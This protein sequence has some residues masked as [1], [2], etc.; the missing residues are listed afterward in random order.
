MRVGVQ[1]PGPLRAEKCRT[2]QQQAGAVALLPGAVGDDLATAGCR[3]A[4]RRRCTFGALA[5]TRGTTI[6]GVAGVGR[7]ERPLRV[8]LQPVVQLLDDPG[9]ELGDQRLD[10]HAGE[11]RGEQP[12]EP[13]PSWLRSAISAVAAPGYWILTAT[14]RPS[15]QV[16][17]VHLADAGRR[18]RLVVERW[19]ALAPRPA[20][21]LGEHRVH[22]AHRHRRRRLLQLGQRLAVG[23][24]DLLGQRGLEDRQRLAE[25]HRPALE[26]AQD[27]EEL[28]GGALLQ[29]GGDRSAGRPA[30]PLAEPEGGAPGRPA[31]AAA[32]AELAPC[33]VTGPSSVSV[34]LAAHDAPSRGRS[35]A[36]AS[37]SAAAC[38]LVQRAAPGAAVHAR[39]RQTAGRARPSSSVASSGARRRRPGRRWVEDLPGRP[40]PAGAA[41]GQQAGR[42]STARRGLGRGAAGRRAGARRGSAS[43]RCRSAAAQAAGAPGTTSGPTTPGLAAHVATRCGTPARVEPAASGSRGRPRRARARPG[44]RR[45]AGGQRAAGR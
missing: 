33:G 42:P 32:A 27:G 11:E 2:R 6:V 22:G 45:R 31:R 40:A 28:L 18:G 24:G 35:P 30:E 34:L 13:R 17:A 26:L 3:R 25:L 37:R 7:G 29:L 4:T 10:V 15:R 16:A 41:G 21:L 39:R 1:Q 38:R 14:S 19:N 44:R 9:L 23:A 5:T 36:S 20:E 12:G 43:R 8:G